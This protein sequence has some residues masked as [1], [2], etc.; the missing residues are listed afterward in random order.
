[1]LRA[2]MQ[3]TLSK[4]FVA[5]NPDGLLE[6]LRL[7][8]LCFL[9]SGSRTLSI[10]SRVRRVRSLRDQPFDS[11]PCLPD[12]WW[13]TLVRNSSINPGSHLVDGALDKGALSKPSAEEDSVQ[14]QHDPRALDEEQRLDEEMEPQENLKHLAT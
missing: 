9:W 4:A 6:A 8:L 12:S 10:S 14:C 1:M 5:Q 7:C 3:L 2:V 11:V 13:C